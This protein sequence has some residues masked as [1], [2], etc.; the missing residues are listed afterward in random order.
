M[1]VTHLSGKKSVH[2]QKATAAT[3]ES[4]PTAERGGWTRPRLRCVTHS[5]AELLADLILPQNSFV[6]VL[7][8]YRFTP[9]TLLEKSKPGDH[10][11]ASSGSCRHTL[12]V[13][14]NLSETH[15]G[16]D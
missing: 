14:L 8:H 3:L 15:N 5:L 13:S 9:I 2:S 1:H 11:S 16:L 7:T 12:L 4:M 10:A 6:N